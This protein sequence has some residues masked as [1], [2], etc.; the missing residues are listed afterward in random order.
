MKNTGE[1]RS[2]GFHAYVASLGLFLAELVLVSSEHMEA[3]IRY[4]F[5]C[6]TSLLA[7][8]MFKDWKEI[9]DLAGPI[10]SNTMPYQHVNS[11][12]IQDCEGK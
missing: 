5:L 10:F 12:S 1:F 4:P 6:A 11:R 3:D 8:F 9:V 7:G 2:K